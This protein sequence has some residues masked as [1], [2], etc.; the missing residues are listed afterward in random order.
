MHE[1]TEHGFIPRSRFPIDIHSEW[2]VFQPSAAPSRQR[3]GAVALIPIVIPASQIKALMLDISA[4]I[5]SQS[6][7]NRR[8][9]KVTKLEAIAL[10]DSV[11]CPP[12]LRR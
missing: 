8:N 1:E 5:G 9:V 4:L 12:P 11:T 10:T 3:I 6:S 7:S 2:G